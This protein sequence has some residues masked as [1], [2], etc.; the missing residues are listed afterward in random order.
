MHYPTIVTEEI[1]EL[2]PTVN[3][4]SAAPNIKKMWN[5]KRLSVVQMI[6]E[7]AAKYMLKDGL[8]QIDMN[9]KGKVSVGGYLCLFQPTYKCGY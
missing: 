2:S 7:K 3:N 8:V 6:T 1:V 9:M 4:S 5:P